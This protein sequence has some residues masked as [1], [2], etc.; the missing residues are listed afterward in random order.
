MPT[1]SLVA[2]Q[3]E[4]AT[5]AAATKSRALSFMLPLQSGG[6]LTPSA[7]LKQPVDDQQHHPDAERRIRQ[8]KGRPVVSRNM[9]VDEIEDSS[10][11]QTVDHIA[12]GPADDEAQGKG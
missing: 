9:D 8:I 10:Q 2:S 1:A 4:S 12:Q 5:P 7:A 6:S 11:A 3:A